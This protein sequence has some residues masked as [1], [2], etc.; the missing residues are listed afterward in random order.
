MPTRPFEQRESYRDEYQRVF[1]RRWDKAR[2]EIDRAFERLKG[3]D[4]ADPQTWY[5]LLRN[6]QQAYNEWFDESSFRDDA[7]AQVRR[8]ETQQLEATKQAKPPDAPE[9][10]R[11]SPVQRRELLR[12][13]IDAMRALIADYFDRMR[14]VAPENID[15]ET[16]LLA[17]AGLG[18]AVAVG[19]NAY[20]YRANYYGRDQTGAIYEKTSER[21]HRTANATHYR[22]LRTKSANPRDQH[23]ARVG[24][25]YRYDAAMDHPGDLHEC[26]CGREPL[27]NYQP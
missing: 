9:P 10:Q 15:D 25:V 19:H 4:R 5:A 8:I 7:S 24:N 26:K 21:I 14:R 13:Q 27:W 1:R 12:D 23:L 20:K 2:E 16:G 11:L 22:W 6:A 18:A 3:A 17:I